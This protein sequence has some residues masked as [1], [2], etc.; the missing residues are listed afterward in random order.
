MGTLQQHGLVLGDQEVTTEVEDH[1]SL[2]QQNSEL[3][4]VIS[5]MRREMEAMSSDVIKDD[6]P[7]TIA[8]KG[9]P[10]NS[11]TIQTRSLCVITQVILS[12]WK[13]NWHY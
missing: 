1:V 9:V 4:R 10:L 6:E 8:T 2:K 7:A 3:R 11:N 5:E 13:K 12:S